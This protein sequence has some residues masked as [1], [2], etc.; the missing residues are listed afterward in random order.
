[1]ELIAEQIQF[2]LYS[3]NRG[4]QKLLSPFKE[5]AKSCL[6]P[7][8]M[9]YLPH[10][11]CLLALMSSSTRIIAEIR[12]TYSTFLLIHLGGTLDTNTYSFTKCRGLIV[13]FLI[14]L[15]AVLGT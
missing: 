10:G 8:A 11:R 3:V 1:M 4:E 9:E 7:N 2:K 6:Q 15:L 12:F 5:G 14:L 13:L